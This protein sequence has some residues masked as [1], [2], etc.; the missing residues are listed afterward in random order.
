MPSAKISAGTRSI[1]MLTAIAAP[2]PKS[3]YA[4]GCRLMKPSTSAF[5]MEAC[6]DGEHG[7]RIARRRL[8]ELKRLR[9]HHDRQADGDRRRDDAEELDASPAP[10]AWSRASSP[11]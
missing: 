10:P 7:A 2:A 8:A 6:G 11:S 4:T 5:M 3:T 9:Q 1:S